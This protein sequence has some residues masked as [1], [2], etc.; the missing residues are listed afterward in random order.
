MT[1]AGGCVTS[2]EDQSIFCFL[3][4]R[5]G[6]RSLLGGTQCRRGENHRRRKAEVAKG[7]EMKKKQKKTESEWEGYRDGELERWGS[8]LYCESSYEFP[9]GQ[10]AVNTM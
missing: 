7:R 1:P 3:E 5:K 2:N 10:L 4:M 9:Q 8:N 6:T